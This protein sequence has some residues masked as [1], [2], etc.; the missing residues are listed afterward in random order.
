MEIRDGGPTDPAATRAIAPLLTIDAV[1]EALS[2]TRRHIQRLVAGR[3]IPFLKVGRFIRFDPAALNSGSKSS[4]FSPHD[5]PVVAV[6]PAG[7]LWAIL[8]AWGSYCDPFRRRS[9]SQSSMARCLAVEADMDAISTRCM[10]S[11][12][13]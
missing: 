9:P 11:G 12:P 5:R 8:V 6:Q 13:T 2:V 4:R 10:G 1:A 3:R 7:N